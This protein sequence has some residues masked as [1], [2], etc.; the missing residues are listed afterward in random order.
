MTAE[1]FA[2]KK[3]KAILDII[4]MAS[5]L[6]LVLS[7]VVAFARR[8]S[9]NEND[10]DTAVG[11]HQN[12]DSKKTFNLL[13]MGRDDAANLCDVIMVVSYDTKNHTVEVMQ[14]PRDTYASYTSSSY[15]KLNG[16]VHSLGG[17]SEFAEF[18]EKNLGIGI[19]FYAVTD[20]DT[21]AKAVD[22]IGGVRVSI[23]EDMC[24]NDPY[25][26]LFIDLKAGEHILNGEQANAFLRYRSGY[27]QGD[28]GRLDAQKIFIAALS[29]KLIFEV[30]MV[31][32]VN[33][34]LLFLNDIETDLTPKDCIALIEGIKD[35]ELENISFFTIPGES[36]Q[37][38]GGAWYYVINKEQTF[39]VIKTYFSPELSSEG[40]DSEELFTSEYQKSFN[41]IYNAR[42]RYKVKRYSA[43]DI[44]Q[45][46]IKID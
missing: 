34:A 17:V 38:P 8:D 46:G 44:C 36:V 2:L 7:L 18:L 41:E 29:K 9:F 43:N 21:V 40:F 32:L 33:I 22:K 31:D 12:D 45:N 26:S 11:T 10:E 5:L 23:E 24:Y 6:L 20:L 37:T 25:Q 19:D 13:I 39:D 4:V 42:G 15:R 14:I 1:G 16:A 30:G 3:Q 28:I 27:V 35:I